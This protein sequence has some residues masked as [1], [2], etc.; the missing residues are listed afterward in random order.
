MKSC[1]P[2]AFGRKQ[3]LRSG[4]EKFDEAFAVLARCFIGHRDERLRFAL[5]QSCGDEGP[6]WCNGGAAFDVGSFFQ[7]GEDLR[8]AAGD[9]IT[10]I[11]RDLC[12]VGRHLGPQGAELGSFETRWSDVVETGKDDAEVS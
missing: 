2:L 11:L 8:I 1:R 4:M 12:M 7:G 5:R 10:Q 3:D 9:R 6:G